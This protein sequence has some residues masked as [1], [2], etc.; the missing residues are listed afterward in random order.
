MPCPDLAPLPHRSLRHGTG[1]L[2][3][4]ISLGLHGGALAGLLLLRQPTPP[5]PMAVVA[6]ELGSAS[7]VSGPSGLDREAGNATQ[8]DVPAETRARTANGNA[9]A[10]QMGEPKGGYEPTREHNGARH[11][12]L[13]RSGG[14]PT[15]HAEAVAVYETQSAANPP[16]PRRKPRS[17][18]RAND[19]AL[20]D[21]SERI[22]PTQETSR[23]A[24]RT[25]REARAATPHSGT[26][27]APTTTRQAATLGT[28]QDDTNGERLSGAPSVGNGG[29]SGGRPDTQPTYGGSGLSNEAPRYPYLARR[30]GQ[31]GRVVLLVHVSAAGHAIG[32][33]LQTSSGYHLLDEAALEAVK[34][35]RFVPASRLGQPVAG[36]VAVPISF[37]LH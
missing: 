16:P 35:W 30:R 17:V 3:L 24:R 28:G 20:A 23:R 4:A 36:S 7:E 9:R 27:V 13:P 6:I 8:A 10:M 29:G 11:H 12:T 34:T 25:H 37:K 33:R 19:R 22:E 26:E 32:V 1:L 2:A 15:S 14:T 18:A 31:E 5:Q 21:G